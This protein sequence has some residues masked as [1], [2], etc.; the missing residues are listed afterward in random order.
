MRHLPPSHCIMC[1]YFAQRHG[2]F[3]VQLC[4]S[5]PA[6]PTVRAKTLV[7]RRRRQ[8]SVMGLHIVFEN[9]SNHGLHAAC[10]Y[11]SKL[12]DASCLSCLRQR[13]R[14]ASATITTFINPVQRL[15]IKLV[16]ERGA[17]QL[18]QRLIAQ[19]AS[20]TDPLYRS[21]VFRKAI[22]HTQMSTTSDSSSAFSP[23]AR[24]G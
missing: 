4:V 23:I 2:F 6:I 8:R 16:C 17:L 10:A 7:A 20:R 24:M 13:C 12:H 9:G 5:T 22:V 1:T 19:E 14:N 21:H 3:S 11:D 15:T 18:L